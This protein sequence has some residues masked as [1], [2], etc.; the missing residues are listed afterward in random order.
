MGSIL[1]HKRGNGAA[2]SSNGL[3]ICLETILHDSLFKMVNNNC[4]KTGL[5]KL[6][7]WAI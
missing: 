1:A 5:P 2:A 6:S 4:L 7:S 3:D